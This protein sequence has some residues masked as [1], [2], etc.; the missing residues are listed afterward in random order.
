MGGTQD[1]IHPEA[2]FLSSYKSVQPNKACASKIQCWDRYKVYISISKGKKE[3]GGGKK[4][5]GSQA[6]PKSSKA[7]HLRFL[8]LKNLLPEKS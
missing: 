5:D 3:G 2:K 1:K 4:D 8:K 6:S 7:N